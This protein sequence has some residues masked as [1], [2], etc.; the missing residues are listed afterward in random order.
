MLINNSSASASEILASSLKESYHA[1]LVGLKTYGK[2]TVQNAYELSDGSTLKYTTQKWLTAK[3]DWINQKGIFP[4]Y[5]VSLS[6]EY[7]K[8]QTDENDNQLQKAIEIL[9]NKE[10]EKTK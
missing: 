8:N 5:E 4:D 1:K 9:T 7:Y 2:G 3:G 10:E 6:E